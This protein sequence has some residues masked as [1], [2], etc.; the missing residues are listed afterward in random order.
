MTGTDKDKGNH[1]PGKDAPAT[2]YKQ[3]DFINGTAPYED[4][5]KSHGNQ[6][7]EMQA[8]DNMD[9]LARSVKFIGFR[10]RYQAY[11]RSLK[12]IAPADAENISR[13]DE[14]PLELDTGEWRTD[15]S[16]VWKYAPQGGVEIACPHPIMP[17]ERLRNIDTGE[18]K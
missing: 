12:S 3:D 16:G 18:L 2:K 11:C 4:V 13:F 17:V 6:F 5:Y 8:I 9:K 14:Q 10:G 7:K 1:I 15:E